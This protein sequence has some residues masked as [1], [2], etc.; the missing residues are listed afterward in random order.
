MGN[1]SRWAKAKEVTTAADFWKLMKLSSLG[2]SSKRN[3]I[4]LVNYQRSRSTA[5]E[6]SYFKRPTVE[7]RYPESSL[8]SYEVKNWTRLFVN[9]V[10]RCYGRPFPEDLKTPSFRDALVILGLKDPDHF[11]ILSPG[12]FETKC[13]LLYRLNKYTTKA[14]TQQ[15]ARDEWRSMHTYD[16]KWKFDFPQVIPPELPKKEKEESLPK[17]KAT[18]KVPS[19]NWLYEAALYH[20]YAH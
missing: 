2:A 19:Y 14:T 7:L 8:E 4:T 12:L 18:R 3:T 10:D 9:F 13:W 20:D 1:R 16:L 15:L 11:T 5:S 17:K 6:W